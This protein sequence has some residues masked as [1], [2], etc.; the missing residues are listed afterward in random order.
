MGG[1]WSFRILLAGFALAGAVHFAGAADLADTR[2]ST[3]PLMAWD[4]A[5]D[6]HT[7]REMAE[8]G[9]TQVGFV[10]DEVP[11]LDI[12]QK[13]GLQAIVFDESLSGDKWNRILDP[14]DLAKN[15]PA[16]IEKVGKRPAVLG[17]H[18]RDEPGAG[19][20]PHLA[21]AVKT[22][23]ELAP[24]K[25]P[26]INLL[27]GDDL[28][29]WEKYLDDFVTICK[30]PILSYDRYVI[31]D[32]PGGFAPAFWA[33][34][35][36]ARK[37]ALRHDIPLYNIV[38]TAPH[39]NYR[40]LTQTDVRMQVYGSLVYGVKGLGY[41]KF[42][43]H[44]LDILD[45]PPL[46]NFRGGPLDEFGNRTPTWDWLRNVNKQVQN[47]A[48]HLLRLR[49]DRVYHMGGS[50]PAANEGATSSSLIASLT[51]PEFVVGEFTHE[52]SSRY[53]MIVNRS[54]TEQT[55]VNVKF[56]PYVEKAEF[57]DSR[58]GKLDRWENYYWLSPGQGV[59]IKLSG[60]DIPAA[61]AA[62]LAAAK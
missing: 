18:L 15:L 6:E 30:P 24:G 54:M 14:K 11:V 52:D 20:Y 59:L 35:A 58:T 9:I 60:K 43:S 40:D 48:P 37:V 46:G 5:D 19:E 44:E 55:H 51:G 57:V 61:P 4:Y 13:L 34:L 62:D 26:Y 16:V 21:E 38:L 31:Y 3:F 8:C 10:P 41:Y 1:F 53:V 22:V 23:N 29:A 2:Q 45:A 36:V 27:P 49:S 50:V 32:P 28:V 39:W 12:C 25:W 17:Y 56:P 42:M 33:N 7:L 47:L